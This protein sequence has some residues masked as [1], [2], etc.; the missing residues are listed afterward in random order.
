MKRIRVRG[1]IRPRV[2]FYILTE[3]YVFIFRKLMSKINRQ[4]FRVYK[5][6]NETQYDIEKSD[7]TG[8]T[9]VCFRKQNEK[10]KIEEDVAVF[11]ITK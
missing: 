7:G 4:K 8:E 1:L 10:L 2:N 9:G 6:N 3:T 11:E 5:R